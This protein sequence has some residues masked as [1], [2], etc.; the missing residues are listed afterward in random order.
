MERK[1]ISE[2][3]I[4]Q[5]SGNIFGKTFYDVEEGT[6][7]S[8][9][10][11]FAFAGGLA[12]TKFFQYTVGDDCVEIID[13][14]NDGI[15]DDT[16]NCVD[17]P[18]INQLDT[19]GD[20]IGDVCDTDDDG[21]GILD[22]EDNCPLIANVDQLD[23]DGDG[24]GDVCD[25][26]DDGDGIEDSQDNCPLTVNTDQADWDSDGIGDLCGDPPP[27][28][29]E[30]VTFVENIYPNPTDDNLMVTL[31]PGSEYKDLYFVDLSGKL[32]KPRSVNRIQE[33]LEV[34]VS[35]L[36]EGVYIL[37]IVT[38]KEINKVKVVIER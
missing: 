21:D 9:A 19:D 12:V 35:N 5:I 3:Q 31:K 26:D 37:K 14:D 2:T 17:V 32:I 34:N 18:N 16:D 1:S 30:N 38:D 27:L 4:S 6:K 20:G 13:T 7:L 11:K 22:T 28:F 15:G 24:T 8:Y 25:T 10:C 29:T 23:T 33:G 36:N